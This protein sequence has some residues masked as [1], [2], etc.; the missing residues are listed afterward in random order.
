MQSLAQSLPGDPKRAGRC[1]LS[2]TLIHQLGRL[3]PV[4]GAAQLKR[5]EQPK[6]DLGI[7]RFEAIRHGAHTDVGRLLLGCFD[8]IAGSE[9]CWPPGLPGIGWQRLLDSSDAYPDV[10][11]DSAH[12]A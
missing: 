8:G 6:R 3:P 1:R 2:E 11:R 5:D 4:W 12:K 7:P 10:P 9:E